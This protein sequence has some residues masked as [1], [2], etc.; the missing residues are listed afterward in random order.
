MISKVFS[1]DS[2]ETIDA[3]IFN[4]IL[5]CAE[6]N[7]D[8]RIVIRAYDIRTNELVGLWNNDIQLTHL[9]DMDRGYE[10]ISVPRG[11]QVNYW[12]F[13]G[14]KFIGPTVDTG[15]SIYMNEQFQWIARE[16]GPSIIIQ[17][18]LTGSTLRTLDRVARGPFRLQGSVDIMLLGQRNNE[19]WVYD[20]ISED[21]VIRFTMRESDIIAPIENFFIVYTDGETII[22]LDLINDEQE[23]IATYDEGYIVQLDTSCK[24]YIVAT[25]SDEQ[26]SGSVDVYR[27]NLDQGDTL[28]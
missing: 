9:C 16:I 19:E 3:R 27:Y 18:L 26:E 6:T 15:S 7:E 17:D 11:I 1:L 4:D 2:F 14:R 10:L 13:D 23:I 22:L 12:N 21:R 8:F 28:R 24:G 25:V 5:Y 20:Y